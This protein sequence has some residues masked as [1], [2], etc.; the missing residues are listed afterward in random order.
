MIGWAAV[1]GDVAW[2]GDRAVRHH[3]F[4]DAAA[5]LGARALTAPNDYAKAGVPML[6]VVAGP[7]ETKRQMLLYTL[8]LWPVECGAVVPRDCRR[9]L[10]GRFAGAERAVHGLRGSRVA[11]RTATTPRRQMFGFSLL[12][13][14]LIFSLLLVD[15][16]AAGLAWKGWL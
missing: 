3:L 9:G 15:R 7:R 14:M 11:R 6:P 1:T 8:V 2:G 12:Y 10:R 4:L 5:F 13:L 16:A